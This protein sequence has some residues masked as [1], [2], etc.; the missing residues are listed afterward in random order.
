[1]K[2]KPFRL[3]LKNS[4]THSLEFVISL[5]H[6][7]NGSLSHDEAK[8]VALKVHNN[9]KALVVKGSREAC[10]KAARIV[11]EAGEDTQALRYLSVEG[12]GPMKTTIARN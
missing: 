12:E 8:A 5:V 4:K 1:M 7:V 3:F 2:T 11:R 9:G 6:R 10:R